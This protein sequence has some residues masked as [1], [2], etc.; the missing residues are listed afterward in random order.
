LHL[1][2]CTKLTVNNEMFR[3]DFNRGHDLVQRAL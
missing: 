3:L 2:K 1:K